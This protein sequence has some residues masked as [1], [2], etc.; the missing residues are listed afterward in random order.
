MAADAERLADKAAARSMAIVQELLRDYHPRDFAVELGDGTQLGP[1]QGQFCRFTWRINNA[2]ALRA[3]F[4]SDQQVALGEAYVY[5]DFDLTGDILAIFPLAEHLSNKHWSARDKLR[6]GGL[7]LGLPARDDREHSPAHLD[8]RLHSKSRDRNAVHFHYDLS[9][10]FYQLWLDSSMVY[11]CAYFQSAEDTL[12]RAQEQK[13]EYICRKLRLRPGERLLDIGCGWGGLILHAARNYGVR[14]IGITL[15]QQQSDLANESIQEAALGSRCEVHL[16]DYRDVTQLGQFDKIVSVGMV[17]HVGERK[18]P[19]YFSAAFNQL[20]PG[21][22]FLNHGI[23]QA[24]NRVRPADPTFTDVYV[25][26]DGDL[27][28]IATMLGHAEQT[29]FEVRDVENLRE[30]YFLTLCHWLRRLEANEEQARNLV[31][32]IKYRIW[33][34]YLAGS[35]YYFRWTKLGLYQSLFAKPKRGES[36]MPLTRSDWYQV[37]MKGFA[38]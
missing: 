5:G 17:E 23:G 33:R 26:P 20:K 24:G 14:A 37:V 3:L 2:R 29:G 31:G 25:F 7:L 35:A 32:D 21:G 19:D 12:D 8:G 22:V 18:L 13:L 38:R 30:H 36:G 11:S 34:L 27:I 9:N 10:Q 4:R 16:I 6:I 15:S 28:P 1:D